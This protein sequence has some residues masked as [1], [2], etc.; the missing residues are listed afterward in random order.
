MIKI[1]IADDHT[2]FL[3]SLKV[4]L[5][6]EEEISVI[7]T[8]NDGKQLLELIQ[9]MAPDIVLM[10]ISMP[11]MNGIDAT[12]IIRKEYP[13]IKVVAL[14]MFQQ[15]DYIVKMVNLDVHGYILKDEKADNFV[16]AI[17]KIY[18]G[19]QFFSKGVLDTAA[20][21]EGKEQTPQELPKLSKREREVLLH[22][23]QGDP[24][25]VVADRLGITVN[26]VKTIRR[27]IRKKLGIN[28]DQRIN[29]I[30]YAIKIGLINP[31][32]ASDT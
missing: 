30:A 19:G 31:N 20:R 23:A 9:N 22:L 5:S 10:D 3:D 15:K 11:H 32:D 2:L 24:S 26:T 18:N 29:L 7:G 25:A 4:M 1:V 6:T 27:N 14:S 28:N 12:E 21:E 16:K 8:A 13:D 17:Q